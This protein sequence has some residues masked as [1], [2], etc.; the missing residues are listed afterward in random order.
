MIRR[1]THA[2]WWLAVALLAGCSSSSDNIE[3]TLSIQFNPMFSGFDG[4]HPFQI[5]ATIADA[6]VNGV[7]N[8]KWSASDASFVDFAPDP[9]GIDVMI[10]TKKAGS[11]TIIAKTDNAVGK[12][13]LTIASYTAEQWAAGQTRYTSGSMVMVGPGKGGV[14]MGGYVAC[15]SCH[16]DAPN[17]IAIQHTPAQTGGFTDDQIKGIF[18]HGMLPASDQNPLAIDPKNFMSFHT[19]QTASDAESDGLVA[20]LRSL[21]PK[22]QGPIGGGRPDGGMRPDGGFGNHDGGHGDGGGF[23]STDAGM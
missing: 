15:T 2:G 7:A 4:V 19:W 14:P 6:A 10:T 11:V 20:Y 22:A 18:L 9:N 16:G 1:N 8:V 17:S 12:V 3:Q 5:P 23:G 13:K 21:T